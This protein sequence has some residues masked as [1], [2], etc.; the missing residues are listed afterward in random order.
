MYLVVQSVNFLVLIFGLQEN[1]DNAL[2]NVKQVS[3]L[4]EKLLR[5][6]NTS[7]I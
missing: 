1:T 7:N 3:N 5:G 4:G 6:S 2:E